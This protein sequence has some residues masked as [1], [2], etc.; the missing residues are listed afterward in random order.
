VLLVVLNP[1][2]SED[3][4]VETEVDSDVTLLLVVLSPLDRDVTPLCA[5]MMPVEAE[6]DSEV[7][8]L[9]A[10]LIPVEAKVETELRLLL[11]VLSP[12]DVEVDSEASW[13]KLTASV[14]L[15]PD[16]TLVSLTGVVE[17]VP[18]RVIW[19]WAVLSY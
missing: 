3:S 13:P 4:L 15:T 12:V 17:P 2:A 7:T 18:P 10:L 9:C 19:L 8:L 6:V 5:V 14:A 11:A 16:A 1:L